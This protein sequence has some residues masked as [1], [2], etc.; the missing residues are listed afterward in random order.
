MVIHNPLCVYLQ[1]KCLQEIIRLRRV[2]QKVSNALLLYTFDFHP[3]GFRLDGI[4]LC[5]DRVDGHANVLP[6]VVV[7]RILDDQ[8]V[9]IATLN[10]LLTTRKKT[11]LK[12]MQAINWVNSM[13]KE[14]LFAMEVTA[15]FIF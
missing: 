1:R 10:N 3:D 8:L 6:L 13:T 4:F 14:S 15:S 9:L 12:E 11:G 7:T 2:Q 5:V